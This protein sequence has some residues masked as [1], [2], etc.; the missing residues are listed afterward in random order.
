M[1]RFFSSLVCAAI[2]VL[3]VGYRDNA[4]DHLTNQQEARRDTGPVEGSRAEASSS[5]GQK[6]AGEPREDNWYEAKSTGGGFSVLLP[7]PFNDVT[8]SAPTTDGKILSVHTLG[9]VTPAGVK[10]S[11][12]A[13]TRSDKKKVGQSEVQ[14]VVERFEKKGTLKSKRAISLR[15]Y[16]GIEFS[17]GDATVSARM[18][19]YAVDDT[20]Y[21]LIV[22][23]PTSVEPSVVADINKFLDSLKLRE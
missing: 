16:P 10:F 14:G 7:G 20:L 21:Q 19:T 13:M 15:G 5:H 9:M 12:T 2:C 11:A 6:M 1:R 22:E 4:G 8:Q 18:R 17:V 23:F 3:V